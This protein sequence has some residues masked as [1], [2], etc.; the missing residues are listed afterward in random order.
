LLLFGKVVFLGELSSLS[1]HGFVSTSFLLGKL[2]SALSLLSCHVIVKSE[3][4]FFDFLNGLFFLFLTRFTLL[5]FSLW[6]FILGFFGVGV[7]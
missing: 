3:S 6:L 2:A 7:S 1:I 5:A 4:D